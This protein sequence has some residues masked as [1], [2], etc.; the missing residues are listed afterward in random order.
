MFV[1][2]S[3]APLTKVMMLT[4]L[5]GDEDDGFTVAASLAMIAVARLV[6]A[7]IPATV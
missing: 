2:V 4:L 5:C 6:R 1:E 7:Q 3:W